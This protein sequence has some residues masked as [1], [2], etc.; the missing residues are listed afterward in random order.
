M[1]K[2]LL[3]LAIAV[4]TMVP[5]LNAAIVS[6]DAS[7]DYGGTPGLDGNP[8][9]IVGGENHLFQMWF[10]VRG[11]GGTMEI[12]LPDAS[13]ENE[14]GPLSQITVDDFPS[15]GATANLTHLISKPATNVANLNSQLQLFNNT[16]QAVVYDVF[17]YL[18]LDLG[19][20]SGDDSATGGSGSLTIS[21]ANFS[22]VWTVAGANATFVGSFPGILNELSD[23][24]VSNFTNGGTPFGP[25]DFTGV[26]QFAL[27]LQP[28]SFGSVVTDIT[29]SDNRAVPEPGTLALL[30]AGLV[31]LALVR[32]RR[33]A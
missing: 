3:L 32:R 2:R 18:D 8:Q 9:F 33:A 20:T 10:F 15:E 29:I 28:S 22:A 30:G 27:T 1:P 12:A 6:G 16:D 14:A 19:E 25:G 5:F 4:I 13:S 31:G 24:G 21:D 7:F 17:V 26:Y 11:P 23:T